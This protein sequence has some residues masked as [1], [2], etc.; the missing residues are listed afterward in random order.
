M[1]SY[2]FQRKSSFGG[3]KIIFILSKYTTILKKDKIDLVPD[4]KVFN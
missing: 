4:F 1:L 2:N 3:R